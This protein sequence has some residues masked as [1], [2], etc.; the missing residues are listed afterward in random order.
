MRRLTSLLLTLA[1]G[2]VIAGSCYWAWITHDYWKAIPLY[3]TAAA[4][5]LFAA[6]AIYARERQIFRALAI[7]AMASTVT[8]ASTA[9]I[10]LSRWEI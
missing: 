7:G 8:F 10:T 5:G 9:I 4:A 2:T 6:V 3:P 1:A